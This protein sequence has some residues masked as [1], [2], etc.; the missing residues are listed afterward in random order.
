MR[1]KTITLVLIAGLAFLSFINGAFEPQTG[2]QVGDKAPLITSRLIDGTEFNTDSLKGKM[3]LIDF[4]ASYDAPS[5]ID[6]SRKKIILEKY[7][8][9]EFFNSEGFVIVS[10][11]L[12]LYRTPLLK[13]IER[14]ALQ[15]FFHV[16]DFN[17]RESI[18]AQLFAAGD[19]LTNVLIDGDGRIVER[20]ANLEKIEATL[21]RLESSNLSQIAF[22]KR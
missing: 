4:W 15:D 2:N 14:D 19:E 8:N 7:A 6:N 16:C 3:V 20:S 12:D 21:H 10:V 22:N 5:R 18:L 1:V 13:S 9:S 17:G 11:S